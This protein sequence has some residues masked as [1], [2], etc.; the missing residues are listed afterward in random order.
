MGC[1]IH[2]YK[3]KLV[4]GQWVTADDWEEEDDGDGETYMRVSWGEGRF[5]ERSYWLFG[6]L[7][8]NVRSSHPL[9]FAERGMPD[10]ASDLVKGEVELWGCDGHSHSHL[11]LQ[12]LK[13][14]M[15]RL[16]GSTITV[17]G[18]MHSEQLN[19]FRASMKTETPDYDL[20][21]PY[22]R[23]STLPDWEYF[24]AEV[25]A[26]YMFGG[27]L[28]RLIETFDGVDGDNQ[29]LVFFFDN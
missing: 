23:Y 22:C 10:D 29:R 4:D 14:L 2:C 6:L 21:Y 15:E 5:S 27:A 28:K 1:D 12:E 11:Y 20:L 13:D 24:S 19:R 9:S 7:C 17:T 16:D 3:E 18:M 8:D 25:P 26:S